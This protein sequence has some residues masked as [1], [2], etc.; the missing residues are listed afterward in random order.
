VSLSF[1]NDN[2]VNPSFEAQWTETPQQQHH[3]NQTDFLANWEK[4]LGNT[5]IFKDN[6]LKDLVR[7]GC[8]LAAE[9]S[10]YG[11]QIV[12]SDGESVTLRFPN[13]QQNVKLFAVKL[14][15]AEWQCPW[16]EGKELH[17]RSLP[18]GFLLR[19][20]NSSDA[21][22]T[23]HL[24]SAPC[25]FAIE[26]QGPGIGS[27]NSNQY[28][29]LVYLYYI[30]P[31]NQNWCSATITNFG[32]LPQYITPMLQ[33]AEAS[34]QSRSPSDSNDDDFLKLLD[35]QLFTPFSTIEE[36]NVSFEE[37]EEALAINNGDNPVK[38]Y[39]DTYV[40]WLRKIQ[41]IDEI[42]DEKNLSVDLLTQEEDRLSEIERELA[43]AKIQLSRNPDWIY[44]KLLQPG[45]AAAL[46]QW[47]LIEQDLEPA[48]QEERNLKEEFKQMQLQASQEMLN[49]WE[50]WQATEEE[51]RISRWD[52]TEEKQQA[53]RKLIPKHIERE[54]TLSKTLGDAYKK[55][56]EIAEKLESIHS[57]LETL[58]WKTETWWWAVVAT[59]AELQ[60]KRTEELQNNWLTKIQTWSQKVQ[61]KMKRQRAKEELQ[62]AKEQLA[63]A[64]KT[65]EQKFPVIYAILYT[66]HGANYGYGNA[67]ETEKD[68]AEK[69]LGELDSDLAQQLSD[70]KAK[71]EKL[72]EK[73]KELGDE[74]VLSGL[75]Q[76]LNSIQYTDSSKIPD[77]YV[78]ILK[79]KIRI[80]KM[81]IYI[82]NLESQCTQKK[83][84]VE[85][86][87]E[88]LCRQN[89][90]QLLQEGEIKTALLSA[91][92]TVSN[93]GINDFD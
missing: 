11:I 77:V 64:K 93:D 46:A 38:K 13:F 92:N 69:K 51:I 50:K 86:R 65:L 28:G 10:R 19:N 37:W 61:N 31:Q 40:T 59:D 43:Q 32:T 12:A 87:V 73:I 27:E 72:K 63:S 76:I 52:H 80:A 25:C 47:L 15:G 89:L 30:L 5:K 62:Q 67:S 8:S 70:L 66:T 29:S 4:D 39:L 3:Q 88:D 84:Q 56:R 34:P 17:Q 49:E 41:F 33:A 24:L 53:L 60:K 44:R 85:I 75:K 54:A 6:P 57:S 90:E 18:N 16:D 7:C 83:M 36:E 22:N 35:D 81:S 55:W 21:L 9:N 20:E 42:L 91:T 48:Q 45:R 23:I 14:Y 79:E 74:D 58:N 68:M 1:L 82:E 2:V 26:I 71:I 78:K